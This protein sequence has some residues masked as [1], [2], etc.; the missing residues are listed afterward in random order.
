VPGGKRRGEPFA[1]LPMAQKTQVFSDYL[2]LDKYE[3]AGISY[4]QINQVLWNLI[5]GKP[6]A[7]W[8]DGTGLPDPDRKLAMDSLK[9]Q[10]DQPQQDQ[11]P[12]V[13]KKGRDTGME[14]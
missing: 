1:E 3:D 5:E 11:R 7:E 4:R 14:R 10:T 8:L 13:R 9:R 12:Q 2:D 6:R